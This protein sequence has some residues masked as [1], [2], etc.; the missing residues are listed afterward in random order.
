MSLRRAALAGAAAAGVWA[1]LEPID[2]RLFRNDYSDVALLGKA[3]TRSRAWP[4]VGA[5]MHLANGAAF[6][7]ALATLR[8][9][10]PVSGVRL[11]L[12]ENTALYP[13]VILVDRKH[14]ARGGPGLA[15]LSTPRAFAQATARHAVFGFV[16][17]RLLGEE[18]E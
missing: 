13:L 2:S 15:R 18:G 6:G 10:V 4:V 1:A 11:A 12:I 5:A 9:R 16:L 17:D 3:V 7:V 14:P 8:R